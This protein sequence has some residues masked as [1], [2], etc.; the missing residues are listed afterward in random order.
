VHGLAWSG[1]RARVRAR[2][3]LGQR[4][5]ARPE[6]RDAGAGE[7]AELSGPDGCG[8]KVGRRPTKGKILIFH[9]FFLNN[10][11]IFALLSKKNPISQVGPKIK[12]VYNFK[13]Y[14]FALG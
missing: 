13:L 8:P 6:G 10:S 12:V 9:L 2:V 7:S 5:G 3:G 1:R 11:D 4:S 14:N